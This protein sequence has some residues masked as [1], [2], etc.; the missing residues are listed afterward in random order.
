MRI[1]MSVHSVTDVIIYSGRERFTS[2]LPGRAGMSNRTAVPSP[3]GRRR[4]R[5]LL[6]EFTELNPSWASPSRIIR[7]YSRDIE[8]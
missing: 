5:G 7:Q 2:R 4:G 3:P 8:V 6:G 1:M